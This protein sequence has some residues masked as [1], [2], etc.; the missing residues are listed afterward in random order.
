VLPSGVELGGSQFI[1]NSI[2]QPFVNV[3]ECVNAD[4]PLKVDE[5]MKAE[6]S[7]NFDESVN[8]DEPMNVDESG[9]TDEPM[10]ID[11]SVNTNSTEPGTGGLTIFP[12]FAYLQNSAMLLSLTASEGT[13]VHPTQQTGMAKSVLQN[14]SLSLRP[15]M[16]R[17]DTTKLFDLIASNDRLAP[18]RSSISLPDPK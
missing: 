3:A 4:E 9:N 7:I 1:G 14:L 16:N 17:E 11:K 6:T 13:R 10:T 8:F 15:Q 12:M 2:C 18:N 5:C